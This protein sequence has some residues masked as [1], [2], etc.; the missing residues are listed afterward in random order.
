MSRPA[1]GFKLSPEEMA[2]L[3]AETEA[4]CLETGLIRPAVDTYQPRDLPQID[5]SILRQLDERPGPQRP[6]IMDQSAD[7]ACSTWAQ[8][9]QDSMIGPQHGYWIDPDTTFAAQTVY[10]CARFEA[11]RGQWGLVKLLWTFIQLKGEGEGAGLPSPYDPLYLIYSGVRVRW[12]LRFSNCWPP[13][14][15]EAVA[16]P[17]IEIPGRAPWE[18]SFW[19]DLRYGWALPGNGV[20]IPVPPGMYLHLFAHVIS[21][22]DSIHA[23]GGRLMGYTQPIQTAASDKNTAH[24]WNW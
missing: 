21:G 15:L 23:L 22:E 18:L 9:M 3:R 11:Q 12:L 2:Q 10:E 14:P 17:P 16:V 7:P 5:P 1:S 6:R 4:D 13:L 24:G 20:F 19:D 8:R